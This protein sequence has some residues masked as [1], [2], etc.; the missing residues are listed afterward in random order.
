MGKSLREFVLRLVVAWWGAIG[1]AISVVAGWF[2]SGPSGIPLWGWFCIVAT[3]AVV[4]SFQVFHVTR[5]KRDA[6]APSKVR[7]NE[8]IDAA[9]DYVFS[10]SLEG[11]RFVRPG[12]PSA[13]IPSRSEFQLEAITRMRQRASEGAIKVWGKAVRQSVGAGDGVFIEIRPEYWREYTFEET[14]CLMNAGPIGGR[15]R[16]DFGGERALELYDHLHVNAAQVRKEWPPTHHAKHLLRS[17]CLKIAAWC[18]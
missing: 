2:V 9:F 15:T 16:P 6:Y 4:G 8:R 18:E 14:S 5:T 7:G 13:L 11:R 12:A 17:A 1:G 3:A 10:E